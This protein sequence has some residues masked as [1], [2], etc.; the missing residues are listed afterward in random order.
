M[1][2]E[3]DFLDDLDLASEQVDTGEHTLDAHSDDVGTRPDEAVSPAVVVFAESTADV[4][5]VL[6]AANEHEVPVTPYAAGTS[7][8]GNPVPVEGGISLDLTRMAEVLDVRPESF[9]ID[10]QPGVMGPAIEEAL[11]AHGLVFPPLPS[12][13]DIS[14]IGGMIANDASGM[15]TVKYGEISDW[16][17]SLEVVMADGR[18]ITTGTRASKTSSGYNLTELLVGSEGTLG[19]I[20][21]ATLEV[22]PR[23]EQIRGGR[24][25]F[26]T[27]AD[28]TNAIADCVQS[29]LDMAKIE[30]IDEQSAAMANEYLGTDLPS[31]PM[32]F[33]EF[34]ANHGIDTE[35]EFGQSIIQVHDPMEM[36]IADE[37]KMDELWEARKQLAFAMIAYDPELE[38]LHPGD[39]TVPIDRY[40]EMIEY[41]RSLREEHDLLIPCFGHGGD[42]NVHYSVLVEIDDPEHV[43]LGERV[44][45]Q[46][47]ERALEMDGTCTGE[48][49]IGR[50]KQSYLLAEHGREAVEVMWSVKQ[51]LD[52]N[53]ILNPGKI[54]PKS[55]SD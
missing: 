2:G 21:R 51:A 34:H 8:E 11:A 44:S 12:S 38:P 20:T 47:V 41:I 29:G 15:Q 36:E 30:L 48:H 40:S 4:S 35:I 45:K 37:G 17:L 9:Q 26:S 49:G 7:L 14:T 50:G 6:S 53:G 52:P 54:F 1:D 33:L 19:I 24:V 10:V 55:I 42:G 28:A 46:I 25:L 5:T 18:V 31:T 23:P 27:L 3:Y 16:V 22:A 32:V 43:E 13:G 39:V